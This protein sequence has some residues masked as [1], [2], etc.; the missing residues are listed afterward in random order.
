MESKIEENIDTLI[1]NARTKFIAEN[2]LVPA[3]HYELDCYVATRDQWYE[4]PE[5]D[6]KGHT[7]VYYVIQ[8][9]DGSLGLTISI[10]GGDCDY[11]GGSY[12]PANHIVKSA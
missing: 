7:H 5:Y 4:V 1:E 11:S 12:A 6:G 3:N 10:R 8:F 2:G 9:D